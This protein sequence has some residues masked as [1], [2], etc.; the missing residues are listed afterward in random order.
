[1][2]LSALRLSLA[3][4]LVP[5]LSA[6]PN[7]ADDPVE[8]TLGE[9]PSESTSS[10]IDMV[11]SSSEG[12]AES[13]SDGSSDSGGPV[14]T[15]CPEPSA[16]PTMHPG[17]NVETDEVWTADGSPHLVPYDF[18]IHAR[19]VIEPCA[20]VQLGESLTLTV[21]DGGELV[22]EGE[23]AL[24]IVFERLGDER[25]TAIRL[26]G[27]TASFAHAIIDG[28]GRTGNTETDLTGALLVRG[29]AGVTAPDGTLAVSHVEIR[30]AQSPGVR[31]DGFGGF[32]ADSDALTVTGGDSHPISAAATVVGTIPV[33]SY[34]GNGDDRI[35]LTTASNEVISTD[36]TMRDHGLP[37]LVGLPG[38][39]GDL[40]VQA[41]SGL[42]TLTI[43]P[44]VELQFTRE[45]V[46]HIHH[47]G[48]DL[49]ATGAL[50]A[51][52]TQD[53]PILLTSAEDEP[54][55][56]DWL[57]LSFGG[58][59]LAASTRID[60][61]TVEYAGGASPSGS[62]SCPYPELPINDAAVR[63]LGVPPGAFITNT[64][65]LASAGHG[66]DRGWR[67]DLVVEMLASN[68][69]DVLGCRQTVSRMEDGSCP[70]PV[71]CD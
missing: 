37:Y 46:F 62:N 68:D 30:G 42:A 64:S 60:Y 26:Y 33:G 47:G 65:L 14:P 7:P 48:G 5:L 38:Q 34:S 36:A 17:N 20:R 59:T 40:R 66:I 18:T 24:P 16:G 31:L 43:E 50:V 10:D 52:G 63:I 6:C 45:S 44:G 11:E 70:E 28:G 61:T 41:A 25:W 9:H 67:D 53:A 29:R 13:S 56:G 12:R 32:T 3:S 23:A 2:T 69:Y 54:M 22:A 19:V 55:A 27:G 15:E 49:P 58:G 8:T 4:T 51:I 39:I 1:M 35:V 71:P 21:A 57:G